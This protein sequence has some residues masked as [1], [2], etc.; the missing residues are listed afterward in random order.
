MYHSTHDFFQ[1]ILN[2]VCLYHL[3]FS[4]EFGGSDQG[5]HWLAPVGSTA[6]ALPTKERLLAMGA[7]QGGSLAMICSAQAAPAPFYRSD[8]LV[9]RIISE[10]LPVSWELSSLSYALH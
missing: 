9:R 10:E 3:Y 7:T 6:P 4:N 5:L 2:C 8:L 1:F